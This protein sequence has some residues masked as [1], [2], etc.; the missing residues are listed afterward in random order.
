MRRTSRCSWR[1]VM[2]GTIETL[3]QL[4]RPVALLLCL[5]LLLLLWARTPEC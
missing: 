4:T 2:L 3:I 5:L 1:T